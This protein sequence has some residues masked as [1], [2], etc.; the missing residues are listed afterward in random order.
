MEADREFV[1]KVLPVGA[2]DRAAFGLIADATR[3]RLVEE[4]GEVH[5]RGETAALG[6][7][8]RSLAQGGLAVT[9]SD[10]H[11]A[12]ARFATLWEEVA[13]RRGTWNTA[14]DRAREDGEIETAPRRALPE[15]GGS[16]WKRLFNRR[17]PGPSG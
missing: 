13:R 15:P 3:Y 9:P 5:L 6:Q 4:G 8:L 10:A 11:A 16:L 12:V 14:V 2:V 17:P 7:V 1:E